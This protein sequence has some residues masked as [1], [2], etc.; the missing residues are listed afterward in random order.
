MIITLYIVKT[1]WDSLLK[2]LKFKFDV[3]TVLFK[4]CG[5]SVECNILKRC[6]NS[7]SQTVGTSHYCDI[8]YRMHAHFS[9]F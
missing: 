5:A 2:S 1:E 7:F 6:F 4:F 3:L 9:F 8:K